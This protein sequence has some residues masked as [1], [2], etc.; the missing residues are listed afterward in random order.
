M[1][2]LDL[3]AQLTDT[4]QPLRAMLLKHITYTL[5]ELFIIIHFLAVW[6]SFLLQF[7]RDGIFLRQMHKWKYFFFFAKKGAAAL[8]SGGAK[9]FWQAL[10]RYLAR[11]KCSAEFWTFG[12][13]S[14]KCAKGNPRVVNLDGI[15]LHLSIAQS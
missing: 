3:P 2:S 8:S 7:R 4:G 12:Y 11:L 9:I 15:T 1:G 13:N 6:E 14:W 10:P 5:L